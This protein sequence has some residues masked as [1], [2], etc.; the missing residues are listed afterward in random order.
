MNELM[1][2][3]IDWQKQLNYLIFKGS[4]KFYHLSNPKKLWGFLAGILRIKDLKPL[5]LVTPAPLI[6]TISSTPYTHFSSNFSNS[7]FKS[8]KVWWYI[9][10][11]IQT[12]Q[13]T[14][15]C[16]WKFQE[17]HLVYKI[18]CIYFLFV[19]LF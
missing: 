17:T 14:I 9:E 7:N 5:S 8:L 11:T 18:K 16:T 6:P 2:E 10:I 1:N 15:W 4:S 12:V 3:H 19:Q 13:L